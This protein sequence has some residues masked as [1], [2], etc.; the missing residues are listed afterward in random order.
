MHYRLENLK[1]CSYPT[2][3]NLKNYTKQNDM[4][5]CGFSSVDYMKYITELTHPLSHRALPV[6]NL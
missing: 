1:Y 6:I 4:W 5:Y 3:L 2:H